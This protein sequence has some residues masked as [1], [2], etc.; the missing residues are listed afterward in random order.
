PDRERGAVEFGPYT[1]AEDL[2]QLLVPALADQV[3]VHLAERRQV[4]VGVVTNH[5]GAAVA[6]TD[7][8]LVSVG[9]GPGRHRGREH[10][11]VHMLHRVPGAVAQPALPRPG[12]WPEGAHYRALRGLMSAEHGMRV[13]VLPRQDVVD[14][15]VANRVDGCRH[16]LASAIAASGIGSQSGRCLASYTAS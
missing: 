1:G 12:Q 14:H 3:Q 11:L 9:R 8:E 4:P 5:L 7:R 15:L 13:V 10:A 6:V 2:P 16:L